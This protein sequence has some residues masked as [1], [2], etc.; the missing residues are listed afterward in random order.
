MDITPHVN[1]LRSL[2]GER[3]NYVLL[4]GEG[5]DNSFDAGATLVEITMDDDEI[6]F[7]DNGSGILRKNITSLFSLGEHGPMTTTQLGRFGV[8]I[9]SHAV[10]AGNIFRIISTSIDGR[11]KVEVD[12]RSVL[13]S[14][15]WKID[16]PRWSPVSGK[17][18]TGTTI[19]ISDLRTAKSPLGGWPAQIAGKAA[20]IFYPAIAEGQII[21]INGQQIELLPEPRM[22]H[23]VE[24]QIPL[25]DGRSAHLRAG[26]LANPS[27]LNKVH[28]AYRHRVIMP[29]SNLGCKQYAGL[30][31]MF[32][33][34]QLAGP[35]HLAKFKDDLTDEDEREE[36]EDAVFEVL[37]PILERV[38]SA[39]LSAKVQE[40]S[41]ILNERI[42]PELATS[43]P[44]HKKERGCLSGKK[45]KREQ[46]EVAPE[47]SD[48]LG[49]ARSRR[50]PRDSLLITF[51]GVDEQDGIGTF[52]PGRPHRVNLSRDNQYI[53]KL[54]EYRDQ[55]LAIDSLLAIALAIFEEGH[56]RD[57]L[58]LVEFGKRIANLMSLQTS[59][60]A[61]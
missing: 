37:K 6:S 53:A 15:V 4:A 59:Q 55:Q 54:L 31:K 25:S 48:P 56:G 21:S 14:G 46:G 8:G 18:Q 22:T 45:R 27:K 16:D 38:S 40:I 57:Q 13:K 49:P 28:V 43:R 19:T 61:T 24:Q 47:K 32:A 11:V 9:K 39:S 36:L 23:V 33:R 10:N 2:R 7:Q 60:M 1:L 12:W 5:I 58:R 42:P 34:L 17:T 41:Q 50:T 51:D 30:T 29:S 20:E 52:Q 26:I 3:I 44:K 35:W